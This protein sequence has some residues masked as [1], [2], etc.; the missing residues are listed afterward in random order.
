ML[1]KTDGISLQN[2]GEGERQAECRD[3]LYLVGCH[4][5]SALGFNMHMRASALT[6]S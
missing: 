1:E 3:L 6:L 5:I 4:C 2:K